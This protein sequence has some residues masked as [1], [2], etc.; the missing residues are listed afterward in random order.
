MF[1][2]HASSLILD[3]VAYSL[4]DSLTLEQLSANL[5]RYTGPFTGLRRKIFDLLQSG[6]DSSCNLPDLIIHARQMAGHS[7]E[8]KLYDDAYPIATSG[9]GQV[10]YPLLFDAYHIEWQCFG[11]LYCIRGDLR[12][13]GEIYNRV[14]PSVQSECLGSYP[15]VDLSIQAGVS[16]PSNHFSPFKLGWKVNMHDN[17]LLSAALVLRSKSESFACID[18]DPMDILCGIQNAFILGKCSHQSQSELEITSH[19]CSLTAP[20][21][22]YREI[23]DESHINIVA[24]DGANDLRFLA[25]ACIA[26]YLSAVVLRGDA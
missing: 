11:K 13:E 18:V 7:L 14:N 1:L 6:V 24:V 20:W 26:D 5:R 15:E 23:D 8:Y 16:M 21:N 10:I 19:L 4:F 9:N 2:Q 25:V 3:I 17:S 22:P 12:V